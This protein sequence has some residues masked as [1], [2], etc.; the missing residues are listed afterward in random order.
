MFTSTSTV[1]G[2]GLPVVQILGVKRSILPANIFVGIL[3]PDPRPPA[4]AT[5][6]ETLFEGDGFEFTGAVVPRQLLAV[7]QVSQSVEIESAEIVVF[8]TDIGSARMVNKPSRQVHVH[9]G[10]PSSL[11]TMAVA[12]GLL[13]QPVRTKHLGVSWNVVER[14]DSPALAWN[15][16]YSPQTSP[17]FIRNADFF[18]GIGR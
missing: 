17:L 7:L 6:T 9:V 12:N 14:L 5:A 3:E 2:L 1:Q 11:N 13:I 15:A 18:L 8:N 4:P 16:C 10:V